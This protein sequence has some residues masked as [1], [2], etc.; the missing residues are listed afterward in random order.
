MSDDLT[1]L[2]HSPADTVHEG[3]SALRAIA[4][5]VAP[6]REGEILDKVE[7]GHLAVLLNLVCDRIEQGER[8]A[9]ATHQ[10]MLDLARP[11]WREGI[12]GLR[13]LETVVADIHSI[14]SSRRRK[15][16]K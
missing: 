13:P 9:E 11:G 12:I 15:A 3:R 2:L 1:K 7:K 14:R 4:Q 8:E 6:E 5:L 16:K 10:E